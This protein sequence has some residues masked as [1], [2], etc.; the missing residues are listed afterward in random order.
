MMTVTV[1]MSRT[2]EREVSSV[3]P[4]IFGLQMVDLLI[5]LLKNE[6]FR[7]P[8]QNYKEASTYWHH[9]NINY[10]NIFHSPTSTDLKINK[11]VQ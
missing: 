5:I 1:M 3:L 6:A 10:T 2:R 7:Q 11:V 9:I 4:S 8:L